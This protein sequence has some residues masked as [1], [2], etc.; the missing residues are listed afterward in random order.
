MPL[1]STGVRVTQTL[2]S[3]RPAPVTMPETDARAADPGCCGYAVAGAGDEGL[4]RLPLRS[5]PER[6]TSSAAAK[7]LATT[8]LTSRRW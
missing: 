4:P 6:S 7:S 3:A 5:R 2:A 1:G 8:M